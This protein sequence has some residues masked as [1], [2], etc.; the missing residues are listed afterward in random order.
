MMHRTLILL[1]WVTTAAAAADP[2]TRPSAEAGQWLTRAQTQ[3]VAMAPDRDMSGA[4]QSRV[5]LAIAIYHADPTDARRAFAAGCVD[6][7]SRGQAE[8]VSLALTK[9]AQ[10]GR[11]DEPGRAR[12]ML[13][14]ADRQPPLR[15][16]DRQLLHT[17][18]DV[19]RAIVCLQLGE[20]VPTAIR[21]DLDRDAV[22]ADDFDADGR[23]DLA[24]KWRELCGSADDNGMTVNTIE[25]VTDRAVTRG[26]WVTVRQLAESN[27]PGVN[28]CAIN[29]WLSGAV[30][31][32]DAA[33]LAAAWNAGLSLAADNPDQPWSDGLLL[34][35]VNDAVESV[36]PIP[37]A[38]MTRLASLLHDRAE[39]ATAAEAV[40][41]GVAE[42]EALAAGGAVERTRAAVDRITAALEIAPMDEGGWER[43]AS[44]CFDVASAAARVG[45]TARVKRALVFPTAH[46]RELGAI[47]EE[48]NRRLLVACLA[49]GAFADAA[50]IADAEPPNQQA[51]DRGRIS[52]QL[53]RAG[54]FDQARAIVQRSIPV[55]RV[56]DLYIV[57]AYE[58]KAGRLDDLQK[59]ID[60]EPSPA[61]RA[62]LDV[63]VATT[64]AGRTFA[65]DRA[66]RH[67]LPR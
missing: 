53:A 23:P 3:V 32:D 21:L 7:Q 45:D 5:A 48:G 8:T 4:L 6:D 62:A 41:F 49:G 44:L 10:F 50:A 52:R 43:R 20:P 13:A 55:Q 64:L 38:K 63:A 61:V 19:M 37:Q 59:W 16:T 25:Q 18:D 65:P 67:L 60:A 36:D 26:D 56:W 40:R 11:I 28:A 22:W 34:E 29:R 24:A 35:L 30:R 47:F 33:Q 27:E 39:Y 58:A 17:L 54:R 1:L 9:A 66:M 31:A 46:R 2:G 42:T 57:A 15:S 14:R 51:P 12:A